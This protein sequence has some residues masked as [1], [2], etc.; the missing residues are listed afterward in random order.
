MSGDDKTIKCWSDLSEQDRQA[1]LKDDIAFTSL[2][3]AFPN[4]DFSERDKLLKKYEIVLTCKYCDAKVPAN[5]LR[6]IPDVCSQCKRA[7]LDTP[8]APGA[9][10]D[11]LLHHYKFATTENKDQNIYVFD[12]TAGTWNDEKADAIIK[13]ECGVIFGDNITSQKVNN[14]RLAL[15]GKTFMEPLFSTAIKQKDGKMLTNAQNG[16]VEFDPKTFKIELRPKSADYY[17]LSQIPV[18]YNPEAKVPAKFLDFLAQITLPNEE[19]FINLLEGFGYPLLPGYPVQ[20]V[21]VLVGSGQN[22]KS[23]Y[24]AGMEKFY[25]EKD[26]CHLTLQ[27]L[28]NSAENSP[29]ALVQ[30]QGKLVN[31]ADDLPNKPVRDVGY[32]KMSTGGSSIEAERKFGSRFSFVNSAKFYFSANRMPEVSEDTVA[33]YRRFLFIEFTN[34]ILKPRDQKEVLTEIMSEEQKSGLLNLLLTFVL[35]RLLQQNDFTCARSVEAVAEQYQKH[36]NTGK[37][38]LDKMLEY[39]PNGLIRK[40]DLWDAYQNFCSAKGLVLV[41]QKAFWST[42]K[43]E[44]TQAVEQQYQENGVHK[45]N[46]RGVSFKKPDEEEDP[47]EHSQKVTLEDYFNQDNQENQHSGIFYAVYKVSEYIKEIKKKAGYGGD[48]GNQQPDSNTSLEN[49]TLNPPEISGEPSKILVN[50]VNLEQDLTPNSAVNQEKAS[51]PANPHFQENENNASASQTEG[52][53]VCSSLPGSIS[54]S[55]MDSPQGQA[56]GVPTPSPSVPG[57]DPK[58]QARQKVLNAVRH[59]QELGIPFWQDGSETEPSPALQDDLTDLF[60]DDIHKI[61]TELERVGDVY[62]AREGYWKFVHVDDVDA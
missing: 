58:L 48:A 49:S 1:A 54:S 51:N 2:K 41:S 59:S 29:F 55:A 25:G 44:F 28:S 13:H 27:H 34:T 18:T 43:E 36:S 17:F 16:V 39:D 8:T 60:T 38:F 61:L 33:F 23:T 45:R 35:P 47:I 6:G 37:L 14:V 46:I 19:N 26:I 21:V 52:S 15:Q 22:G 24:F 57:T 9:V 30:L 31:I 11:W 20:R 56:A 12:E 3:S 53:A 42:F 7:S 4:A 62:E 50:P 40:E 5:F 32:F 10:A